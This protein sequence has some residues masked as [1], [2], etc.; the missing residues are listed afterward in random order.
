M[1]FPSSDQEIRREKPIRFF[2]GSP[3]GVPE[4]RRR[5]QS[6][7]TLIELMTVIAIIGI[8]LMIAAPN[9]TEW[10][11]GHRMNSESQKVYFDMLLART[12]AVKNNNNVIVSF[13]STNGNYSVL[14]DTDEDGVQDAGETQKS[15]ILDSKVKFGL[16]G[17]VIDVDGNSISNP[18]SLGGGTSVTFN[19]RGE[20]S[21]SGGV[22]MIPRDDV[23]VKSARMRAITVIQATGG[24]S[25]WKY[26]VSASPP[27]S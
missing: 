2:P 9:F 4:N 17:N 14:N 12:T 24:V 18:I 11:E 8:T 26:D 13:D 20:A 3:V 5:F 25:L 6:G 10:A 7:F 16:N 22:Y 19:S 21:T 15:V 1:G 27:W 23:G